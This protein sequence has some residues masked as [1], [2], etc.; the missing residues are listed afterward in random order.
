MRTSDSYFEFRLV[1]AK[2]KPYYTLVLT[3]KNARV[4][5]RVRRIEVRVDRKS[6]LTTAL[7]YTEGDGDRTRYDFSEIRVNAPVSQQRL[8]LSLPPSVRVETLP[9]AGK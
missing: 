2:A 9:A 7:D 4:A 1:D 3:P 8:R 5:R 6:Y